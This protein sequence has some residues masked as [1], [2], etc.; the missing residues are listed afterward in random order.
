MI[1]V[2][3]NSVKGFF[4]QYWREIAILVLAFFLFKSCTGNS[5]LQLANSSLKANVK[6]YISN[7]KQLVAKNNVLEEEKQKNKKNKKKLHKIYCFLI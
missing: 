4:R 5:E 3:F 2:D 6:T 1:T 7:A